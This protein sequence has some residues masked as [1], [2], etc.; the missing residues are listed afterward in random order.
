MRSAPGWRRPV[1]AV[2]TT[3]L[4]FGTVAVGQSQDL[5]FDVMNS[6]G[7]TLCGS[8]SESCPDFAVV[9]NPSN[10]INPPGFVRVTL[11]FTPSATGSQQ[12]SIMPGGN[13]A[14]VLA[15]GTWN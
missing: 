11:R 13:C 12:C 1:A 2:S 14:T 6:G 7:G 3:V 9:V 4:D 15:R 5:T 10:C 8:V